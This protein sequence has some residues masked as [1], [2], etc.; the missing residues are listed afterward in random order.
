MSIKTFAVTGA[1]GNI[2]RVVAESLLGRGHRVRAIGRSEERLQSLIELSAE[3]QVGSLDD[4]EFLTRAFTGVDAVFTMIPP[5]ATAEDYRAFQ[6]QIGEA[7]ATAIKQANVTQVV[8]L[9][10]I[11]AHLGA[12]TGP[13][14]GLHDQEER[15]N[16]LTDVNV[17]HL[18]P[19]FFM[20]NL[21]FGIDVIKN[22]GV[23]GSGLD[24]Q[25]TIP[26]I[27]TRDIA[28]V[29][30]DLMEQGNFEGTSVRE[31]LGNGN[32]TMTEATVAIGR[33][34]GKDD[35][36]YVQFP[37]ENVRGA[38]LGLGM[39]QNVVDEMIEMYHGMNEGIVQG[40]ESRSA[41]NTTPTTIDEF[42]RKVFAPAYNSA[43]QAKSQQA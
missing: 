13:I 12:G 11:A 16:S 25:V 27:A 6:N 19:A 20:E 43:L 1:T 30:A 22:M 38:M 37:T 23:N 17:V 39:S 36:N 26:M 18:R 21:L 2:G 31:L 8:N 9:S 3:A 34:I 7:L 40:L 42:A 10:S 5:S 29:A 32:L 35:L 24:P 4:A 14:K 15:L 33:A 28:A 41:A